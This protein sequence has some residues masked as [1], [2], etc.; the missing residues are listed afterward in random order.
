M[1]QVIL[2][3]YLQNKEG[4][5]NPK[6]ISILCVFILVLPF[7]LCAQTSPEDFLGHEVG[8]DRKLAD[9][10]QIMA[11][12]QKLDQES[13][14]IKVLTIGT[15][16]L[17]KPMIMAVISSENNI[18]NLDSYREITKKL[19]DAR[20]LTSEDA[21]ILAKEGKVFVLI[22]NTLHATEIG[23][24][25]ESME[26]AHRLVT[27]NTPFDADKVL[28]EV[29]LL[30]IPAANPDGQQMVSDWYRKNLGTKYEGGPMPWLYHHYAGHDNNRDWIT[31][32][33]AETRAL[34]KVLFHDW[35]PQIHDDKHQMGSGGAR[36]F[37]PP[38]VDPVDPN[39]HPLVIRGIDL[40][41]ANVLYDLQQE[42][43]KGVEHARMFAPWWKG[44]FN[45]TAMVHH[46][47]G[48]FSEMASVKVA[49]PI[50]IDSTELPKANYQKSLQFPD[51]WA[52][53]WWRLKDIV[54]Y[55]LTISLSLVKTAYLHK[56]ELLYNFFRMCKESIEMGKKGGPFAFIIPQKQSDYPTT[57]R[58]LEILMFG[59]AEIQQ[60]RESFVA[61]GKSYPAGS[62]VILMSQPY[63]PYV[64][65]ILEERKY[66]MVELPMTLLDN[67]SHTLPMQMGVSFTRI[68]NPFEAELDRLESLPYPSVSSPSSS[69]YIVLDS[70]VNSSYSVVFS[71][72]KENVE[73]FR[74]KENIIRKEF[75][76]A[77][78]SFII[79]NT[80]QVQ[81]SIP[82]LLEKKHLTAYGLDDIT[83]IAKAPLKNH[84]VGLYQSW[85]SNMDEGW[86]R[87]V[88]DDF[89]IPFT[90]LHNKDFKASKN[91]TV[92]LKEKY[93]VI[94][95]A[96]ESA[97]IIKSGTVHLPPALAA[98]TSFV[99]GF[100]PEYEGGIGNEGIAALKSFVEQG[101]I[102]VALNNASRLFMKEFKMPTRDSL[103]G[104]PRAQFFAT[105]SLMKIKVD[106]TSPIGFGMPA[107]AAAMFSPSGGFFEAQ[108]PAFTTWL[109]STGDWERQVVATYPEDGVLM[110]GWLRGEEHIAR[111]AAVIDVK[112]KKGHI[113]LIG[114]LCQ[115]R[116]QT[117]GT[118]KF[119]FNSLLYPEI[120]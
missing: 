92:N 3:I 99:S 84:R 117:H 71:L 76:A 16:T 59:G 91:K 112:Y 60:A 12:F 52:G 32:N 41:G 65:G 23:G 44:S 64:K 58:M 30:L 75:K 36:C 105:K 11:Y 98:Y 74:T 26:F 19:R 27:G 80:P 95:F 82:G 55:E 46:S 86:T 66:P 90:T 78:G 5:M 1:F 70:R 115:H 43:F 81:K 15:T 88:F 25:Q 39:V 53:G 114:F 47:I 56:E 33:L 9:Y 6:R 4:K 17:G 68:E 119:L 40:C 107:E 113:I 18:E 108:S 13:G 2:K 101:G 67:A 35:L 97:E 79:K 20:G 100:P 7:V 120:D 8:A 31:F 63:R 42:G 102:L 87:Y 83:D 22:S 29:I 49:T 73:M 85:K 51:P 106:N 14:K 28:D 69:P 21:R 111:R 104:V 94:V 116:A 72:L 109:P 57:L 89:G 10:N 96:D 62:F 50:Y 118:Y 93:D 61:D 45:G 110:R 103:N 38:F 77:A 34:S 24:S 54:D 37:F 48:V